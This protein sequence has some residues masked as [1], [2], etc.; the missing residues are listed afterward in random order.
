MSDIRVKICGLTRAEDVAAAVD[1]GADMLGFVF[2]VSPRKLEL[3]RARRLLASVPPGVRRVGLFMDQ[4]QETVRRIVEELPLDCLQFH[5][6]EDQDDCRA[7]GLPFVK[8]V[9]MGAD[10]VLPDVAARFPAAE[11]LLLDS[12]APGE[13]GGTGRSFDWSGIERPACQVWLAGG[14]TPGN[15]A[16]AIQAI[17]PQ[18][19]D[20]S[21]GVERSPGIKDHELMVEFIN[22]ARAAV[23]D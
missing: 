7:F 3:E 4:S 20:V 10:S 22:A 17:R 11:A 14:L 1:A 5:G 13:P 19:V 18:L 16:Q 12:H 8:A 21:S 6:A 9:P 2:A 15:V 23:I